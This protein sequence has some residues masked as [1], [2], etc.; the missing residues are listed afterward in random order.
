MKERRAAYRYKLVLPIVVSRIPML[1][2]A[3]LIYGKTRDVSPDGFYF[4]TSQ[5][6]V[7]GNKIDFSLTLP[8]EMT[9]GAETFVIG[10]AKVVRVEHKAETVPERLGVAALIEKFHI[11]RPGGASPPEGQTPQQS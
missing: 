10:Q 11:M 2:E 1:S 4:E 6:F 5:E 3:D 7:L 8:G 9:Q